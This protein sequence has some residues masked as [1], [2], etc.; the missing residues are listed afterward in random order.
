MIVE[1]M[2]CLRG[3][4][5]V[6][7]RLSPDQQSDIEKLVQ[8]GRFSSSQEAVSESVNLLLLREKVRVGIQQADREE[9]IDHDSLFA[10]L[11]AKAKHLQ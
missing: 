11:K 8:A 2:S 9:V 1:V 7:I 6:N 3:D 5:K 4:L 10:E